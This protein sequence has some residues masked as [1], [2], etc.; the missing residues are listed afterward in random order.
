MTPEPDRRRVRGGPRWTAA[1]LLSLAIQVGATQQA[2]AWFAW[3]D[4]LS[5]PGPFHGLKFEFRLACFGP[6][7][8]P[9]LLSK[10]LAAAKFL[11]ARLTST[12]SAGNA[13]AAEA[14]QD[15]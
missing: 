8:Q 6:E 2:Q 12:P 11:A 4:N 14:L 7:S 9:V 5:G 13:D 15:L 3:L 1:V 10:K